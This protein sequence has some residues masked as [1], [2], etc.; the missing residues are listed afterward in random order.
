MEGIVTKCSIVRPKVMSSTHYCPTTSKFT[1]K[2]YRDLTSLGG[3]ATGSSYPTKDG[4]V[5]AP[6]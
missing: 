5:R 6:R 1:T 2:E 4:E 3:V